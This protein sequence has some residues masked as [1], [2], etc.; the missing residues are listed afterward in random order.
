MENAAPVQESERQP[1]PLHAQHLGERI[2]VHVALAGD[3]PGT[4]L[5]EHGGVQVESGRGLPVEREAARDVSRVPR[6]VR[7]QAS[8]SSAAT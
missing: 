6:A 4:S 8:Y 5:F 7:Y 1:V 3:T 2:A